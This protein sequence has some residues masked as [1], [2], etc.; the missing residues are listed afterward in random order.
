VRFHRDLAD[1][2]F[3]THLFIQQARYDPCHNIKNSTAPASMAWTDM[4]TSPWHFGIG[5]DPCQDKRRGMGTR[6][7]YISSTR[8]G[9]AARVAKNEVFEGEQAWEWIKKV[10]DLQYK[11]VID[12]VYLINSNPSIG[13][14][15]STL[16]PVHEGGI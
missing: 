6:A 7:P 13:I 1:A 14:A 11:P 12:R 9:K 16:L 5:L 2:E 10:R 15:K 8:I 4:G 3:G